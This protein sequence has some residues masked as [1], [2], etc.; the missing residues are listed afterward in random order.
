M[1]ICTSSPQKEEGQPPSKSDNSTATK[2]VAATPPVASCQAWSQTEFAKHAATYLLKLDTDSP[3][4]VKLRTW[5][6]THPIA[7]GAHLTDL[8]DAYAEITKRRVLF[9]TGQRCGDDLEDGLDK[10]E[11][12][13]ELFISKYLK[14]GAD[15]DIR[16]FLIIDADQA[17]GD[18]QEDAAGWKVGVPEGTSLRDAAAFDGLGELLAKTFEKVVKERCV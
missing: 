4:R 15:R 12:N 1:G 10:L 14:D 8:L 18:D 16:A 5:T 11:A 6:S 13:A 9:Q 2:A 3:L 17:A 7:V